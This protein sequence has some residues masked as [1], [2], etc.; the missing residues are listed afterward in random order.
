M[1]YTYILFS[2]GLNKYYVGFTE[3]SVELRLSKHLSNHKGFTSK[4]KDWVISYTESFP[5]KG[6]ALK[7]EKQLKGWK[8]KTRIRQLIASAQG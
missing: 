3:G 2:P 6:T 8:N 7:K 4:A 1:F 5:Q